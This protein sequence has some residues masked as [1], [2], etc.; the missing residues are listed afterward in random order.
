MSIKVYFIYLYQIIKLLIAL[1]ND[2]AH[3]ISKYLQYLFEGTHEVERICN[4]GQDFYTKTC[5]LDS[6]LAKSR[7]QP[8]VDFKRERFTLTDKIP[9][10]FY[11]ESTIHDILQ[12]LLSSHEGI[13]ELLKLKLIDMIRTDIDDMY[14]IILREKQLKNI[15][16]KSKAI[17]FDSLTCIFE[18][19]ISF[20]LMKVLAAIEYDNSFRQYV[21]KIW[22]NLHEALDDEL[23][24]NVPIEFKAKLDQKV[25]SI[26]SPRWSYIGFQGEDPGT[27]FRGMGLLALINLLYLSNRKRNL[28]VDLLKRSAMSSHEYPLAIT[29]INITNTLYKLME[30]NQM[31]HF[32]YDSHEKTHRDCLRQ[33]NELYVELF[34]RFDCFWREA[35]PWSILEFNPVMER[36]V[37]VVDCLLKSRNFSIKFSY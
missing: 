30:R 33:V 32:Y 4:N 27:D 23:F 37:D 20:T 24:E 10:E 7:C 11:K 8:I 22:N 1:V 21:I 17:L 28:A 19:K 26:V 16:A 2:H 6:W 34:L 5:L 14:N 13:F 29:G 12:P 36:F 25:E 9:F 15:T 18:Y 3:K 35:K 31:K